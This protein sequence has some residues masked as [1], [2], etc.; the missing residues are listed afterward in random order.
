MRITAVVLV[1]CFFL[2]LGCAM[3]GSWKAIPPPGGCDQC[4]QKQIATD[5]TL[6]YSAAEINDETG[7]RTWQREGSVLAPQPSPLEQKKVT[8]EK[9]FRCHKSPNR[10]HKQYQGR[11]HHKA[12]Y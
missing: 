5:W 7:V 9:C 1:L 10:A 4:H 6:A 2:F 12:F 11:Y 8:E 3:L